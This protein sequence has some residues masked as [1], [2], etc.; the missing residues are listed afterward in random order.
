VR[1]GGRGSWPRSDH[2]PV[3]SQGTGQVAKMGAPVLV[4][5]PEW[6]PY[7]VRDVMLQ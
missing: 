4:T 7:F 1:A 6:S 3:D 2:W 5:A